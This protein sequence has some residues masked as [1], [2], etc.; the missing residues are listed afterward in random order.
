MESSDGS[1]SNTNREILRKLHLAFI[2]DLE[3]YPLADHLL[4]GGVITHDHIEHITSEQTAHDRARNLLW[5]LRRCGTR[6][7]EMFVVSLASCQPHL[8]ELIIA[9]RRRRKHNVDANPGI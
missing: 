7:F 3:I 2:Q 4:Q 1:L 9:E 6:R 8:Y 5:I